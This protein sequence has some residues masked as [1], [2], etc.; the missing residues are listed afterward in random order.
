MR[1]TSELDLR[2]RPVV[3]LNDEYPAGLVDTMHSHDRVQVLYACSGVMS[4]VTQSSSFVIPPQRAVWLPA[5]VE[6]EV[7]CRGAVSLR[8]LYIDPAYD[9]AHPLPRV[10]E[11]SDFLKALILKVVSFGSNYDPAGHEGRIVGVLLEEMA[12][13]PSAPYCAPMPM[14]VRLLRVCRAIVAEPADQRDVS[15]WADFAGMGR[16]TFTRAFRR[17]TG[18]S[19]AIWRQQVRL[20]EA[21]SMIASGR[22]VT[23]VAF[24][25]G[26]E[27]PSAFTAMFR[28]A[29]GVP[30]S[31]YTLRS[32]SGCIEE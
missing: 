27:S 14:D 13:M 24:D 6:H 4:C 17:E 2:K 19:L 15:A 10:I 12:T 28:R 16:R 7:S 21:L 32:P 11:V 30:P 26:Y 18:M 1:H 8:T 22:P 31:T 29:F 5:G 23:M 3:G 20:M 25:V 9:A